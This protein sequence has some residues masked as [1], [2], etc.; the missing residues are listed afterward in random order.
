MTKSLTFTILAVLALACMAF[1]QTAPAN[2]YG[3]GV[4]WNQSGSA[5]PAQQFAGTALYAR[6]Q[7]DKG[8]YA[9]TVLD[10]VPT[11][12]K[13]FTVTTN[14]AVGV[15]QQ[16]FT[17]SNW[18]AYATVAAGPSWSGSNTGWDWYA[19]AIATRPIKGKWWGG[20]NARV[21]KSS[22]NAN[23]GYQFIFGVLGG[24]SQ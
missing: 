8:T 23:S 2:I 22:V 16:V 20:I 13:P 1:A 15:A 7:T 17:L 5:S 6:A 19:G 24:M 18:T 12:Y 3:A 21:V 11:S 14:L 4:S 9:F 10:A